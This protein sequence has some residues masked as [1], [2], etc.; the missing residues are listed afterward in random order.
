MSRHKF[1]GRFVALMRDGVDV[2]E[3]LVMIPDT[4]PVYVLE[5]V[6]VSAL[7]RMD[8]SS[9]KQRVRRGLVIGNHMKRSN[10]WIAMQDRYGG[11][12]M[13]GKVKRLS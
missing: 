8:N 6:L 4:W 13:N 10:E 12:V 3:Y 9:V 2:L 7:R 11:V 5:S 1:A